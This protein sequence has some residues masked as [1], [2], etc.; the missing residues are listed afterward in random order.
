MSQDML[1]LEGGAAKNF[2]QLLR[3]FSDLVS[4]RQS[5][6]V[7]AP[8]AQTLQA[9]LIDARYADRMW[10]AAERMV[11]QRA[12]GEVNT[13]LP[14]LGV[15]H[16]PEHVIAGLLRGRKDTADPVDDL[17]QRDLFQRACVAFARKIGDVACGRVGSHGVTLLVGGRGS[18]ART[19]ASLSEMSSHLG[20][21]ARRHGLDLFVGVSQA[22]GKALLSVGY[23]SSLS[24]AEQA[25]SQ[26]TRVRSPRLDRRAWGMRVIGSG[27]NWI[28]AA[29]R[30][31]V[32]SR[33]AS[34]ATSKRCWFGPVPAGTQPFRARGRRG[35]F[36]GTLARQRG[37]GSKELRRAL[38]RSVREG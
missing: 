15:L 28:R 18:P 23:A 24:A 1:T 5:P 12:V 16:L 11:T 9:E 25:L 20:A 38:C 7:I 10:K 13:E 21:L 22:P 35:T 37:L 30:I 29:A 19:R 33:P 4:G 34:N 3:C 8:R 2:E 27:Q 26:G 17:I 31:L 14:P 32:S 6:D 36:G